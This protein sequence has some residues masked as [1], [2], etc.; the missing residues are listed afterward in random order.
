MNINQDQL[1]IFITVM[2]TGSFSAAARQ[3]G[4]VPSAISM[5]I[6]NLEIDLDLKLFERVG[7][8]PLP[9][10]QAQSLY[11]KSKQLLIEMKQWKQHAFALSSGLE[12]HLNIVVVS[13][14]LHTRWTDYIVLLEQQF[15]ELQ[16][17]IFSAPQ[18][19][20]L[21]LLMTQAADLAFM[22]ER[23]QLQSS[24]QFVE[25]KREILVPVAA[26]HSPLAESDQVSFEQILQNRQIVVASRD[27]QIKPELLFSKHYWRTDNHHSACS[28]IKQG[29]GWGV[30]PLEMLNEHPELQHELKI[31]QLLD[32]T[33]KFEYFVDLV[34]S[35]EHQLGAAAHFLINYVRNLRK[36]GK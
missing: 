15:P 17:N 29:L 16:I 19:D 23:E 4:K 11:E 5:S 6:A 3:L 35:R 28:M 20:A 13:E 36:T 27:R 14:L 24:E 34:W 32:F 10:P 26:R 7:R 2:E 9:T 33:P 1:I 21:L 8:E 12:S 30:L 31:L 25:L 22:F 18:E